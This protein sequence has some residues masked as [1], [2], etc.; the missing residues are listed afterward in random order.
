M[1][2][3]KMIQCT[4]LEPVC[5]IE[6]GVVVSL[7]EKNGK[8]NQVISKSGGFGEEDILNRIAEKIIKKGDKKHEER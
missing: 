4:Q 1:G 2:Y 5:E 3:M 7:L 6:P 8:I